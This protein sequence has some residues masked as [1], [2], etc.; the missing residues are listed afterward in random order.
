LAWLACCRLSHNSDPMT[1]AN[2]YTPIKLANLPNLLL[3]AVS[4]CCITLSCTFIPEHEQLVSVKVDKPLSRSNGDCMETAPAHSEVNRTRPLSELSPDRIAILD[5]NIYKGQGKGW[6]SDFLRLS[7][8][9]NILLLQEAPLND[10][11]QKLLQKKNLYWNLNSAFKY[12]GVETGVLIAST[13]EP[14]GS[15]GMRYTEPLIGLPKTILINRYAVAGSA[16]ELL[17]ATVHGIN[18]TMGIGAYKAQFQALTDVL[19]KHRGPLIIAGDFNNWSDKRT[20][21]VDFLVGDLSLSALPFEDE[22]RTT[23]FGDPVDHFLYRGMEPV[24]H[25][26][27]PVTS[28]DHN[29]ISVTFRLMQRLDTT[30]N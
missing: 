22:G 29:P 4:F 12:R 21:V 20:A 11:L 26:V 19:K 16:D 30:Q 24:A 18:F 5:W 27:H 14:F 23:F 6:E 7:S 8:G 28:S 15:C 2:R 3:L 9:K 10:G 17:V 1:F 13:I 25:M